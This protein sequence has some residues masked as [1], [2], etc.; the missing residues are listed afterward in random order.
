M[1]KAIIVLG[2][3]RSGT[4]L[5]AEL[6]HRWGAYAGNDTQLMQADE[7]NQQGY[8]EYLPLV[9]FNNELLFSVR[10]NWFVPPW[11]DEMLA[12]QASQPEY[13]KKA[14]QLMS[15]MEL[16]GRTWFWKDPRL[17]ILLP[18]WKAIWDDVLYVIPV[19]KPSDIAASLQRIQGFP[20]SASLLLWQD[21]MLSILRNT[22]CHTDKMFLEY[23]TLLQHPSK[24]CEQLSLFLTQR[25][26]IGENARQRTAMMADA[27]T[28]NLRHHKDTVS[29]QDMPLATRHQKALYRF[30]QKKVTDPNEKPDFP[31][32]DLY[33]GWREYLQTLYSLIHMRSRLNK[34]AKEKERV[35]KEKAQ[36]L[37]T[38]E[39]IRK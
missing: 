10:S 8:W 34:V 5:V 39:Q 20:T 15:G 28:P 19:R 37:Q 23:E 31:S 29:F 4:S 2:M 18:F 38:L 16:G 25:T 22:E 17:A 13:S 21:Y 30:L 11:S 27:I 14:R 24:Q 33:Q 36:L 7:W 26:G 1:K 35:L 12:R 6:V 32:F 9:H 3:H